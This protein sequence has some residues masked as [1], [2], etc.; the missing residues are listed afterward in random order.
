MNIQNIAAWVAVVGFIGSG[1]LAIFKYDE[2][3]RELEGQ[4]E[5]LNNGEPQRQEGAMLASATGSLEPIILLARDA[6]IEGGTCFQCLDHGAVLSNEGNVPRYN[7]ASWRFELQQPGIY[8]ISMRYASPDQRPGLIIVN[9]GPAMTNKF[10]EST[11]GKENI[12]RFPQ[13]CA[14]FVSGQNSIRLEH[15]RAFP[16]IESLT[17]TW[18]KAGEC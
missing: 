15:L 6:A 3:V 16:H 11:S 7:A 8:S 13:G 4:L 2:R 14:A 12:Q 17:L 1:A 5:G 10:G 9:G 18:A